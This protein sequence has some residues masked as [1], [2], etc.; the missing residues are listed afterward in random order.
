MAI[1][2]LSLLQRIAQQEAQSFDELYKRYNRLFYRWVYTRTANKEM[3]EDILQNFW[4]LVWTKPFYFKCDELGSAKN[5]FLQTL[6]Y[7]MLDYIKSTSKR[8]FFNESLIPEVSR[9]DAY[10]HVLEDIQAKE[11][12]QMIDEV[13]SK[14]PK[15]AQDIFVMQ[16]EQGLSVKE[17]A[18]KLNVSEKVVRTRYHSTLRLFREQLVK[19]NPEIKPDYLYGLFVLLVLKAI[20]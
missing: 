10:T 16:W 12:Y 14:L 8:H 5:F 4:F 19:T 3:T 7:R 17:T 13:V 15:I 11:I 18:S 20:S 6:T 1:N 2:D 9:A